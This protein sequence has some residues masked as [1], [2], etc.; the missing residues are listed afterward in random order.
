MA[1]PTWTVGQV[2]TAADV[3]SW[4]V[5]VA[6]LKP[7]NQSV[8]SSTTLVNDTALLTA[9]EA[10]ATYIMT[11]YILYTGGVQ[12]SSDLKIAWSGPAGATLSWS[13]VQ[14][15]TSG[16]SSISIAQVIGDTQPLGTTTGVDRVGYLFGTFVTSATPGSLQFR[17]A[18]NTSSGTATTVKAGSW[19]TL[20][21]I[22]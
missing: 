13:T 18:Q 11:G 16:N 17:W 12:G 20:N 2:L 22:S 19:L 3:N 4:L 1:P 8:T 21:R 14:I 6:A 10:N 9:G 5:P 15:S 7:S